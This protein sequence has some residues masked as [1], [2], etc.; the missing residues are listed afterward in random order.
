MNSPM[1]P[2]GECVKVVVR[3]RP[4]NSKELANKNARI[5]DMDLR[6]NCV[7]VK[8]PEGVKAFTFDKIYDWNSTQ[9]AIYK[10]SAKQIVDSVLE[11]YNGTIFAYGQTGTGKTHTMEGRD[12]PPEL[13]GIIP[14]SVQ[15]VYSH[16]EGAESTKEYLIRCCYIEIYNEEIRDLLSKN[17][18]ERLQLKDRPDTGV[19]IQGVSQIVCKDAAE[20]DKLIQQGRKNRSVGETLMNQDSSRSHSILTFLIE[21]SEAGPDGKDMIRAGKLNLVDLAGSE[22]QAKT[23]ATG[24]R[25]KEATKINLSLSALGN[26]ISALVDGKS[27]HIPY[28]DSKLTRLLQDSLGGN[29][30]TC[31][32][33]N[34]G[35]A[36]YNYDETISTLRYANRAKNIKNKAR[37]NEDPKDALMREYKEEINR[38][39]ALLQERGGDIEHGMHAAPAVVEKV[40]EKVVVQKEYV[41]VEKERIVEVE[42][43]KVVEKVVERVIEK[44]MSNENLEQLKEKIRKELM[45]SVMGLPTAEEVPTYLRPKAA[46]LEEKDALGWDL[47]D[48]VAAND[49]ALVMELINRGAEVNIKDRHGM[50]PLHRAVHSEQPALVLCLLVNGAL[51]D[52]KMKDNWTPLHIAAR[53]GNH[54]I[55]DVLQAHGAAMNAKGKNMWTPLHVAALNG[56]LEAMRS[57]IRAKV[58]LNL[59][60]SNGRTAL[61]EAAFRGSLE[62]V[63]E[64]LAAGAKWDILDKDGCTALHLASMNG[65]AEIG[66]LLLEEG[67]AVDAVDVHGRTP[68]QFA[69]AHDFVEMASMLLENGASLEIKDNYG[70]SCIDRAIGNQSYDM[71]TLLESYGA[72]ANEHEQTY[73][74]TPLTKALSKRHSELAQA[75]YM[76][77]QPAT[78]P[79]GGGR[80]PMGGRTSGET[81]RNPSYAGPP[82]GYHASPSGNFVVNPSNG[83]FAVTNPGQFPFGGA[84]PGTDGPPPKKQPGCSCIVQ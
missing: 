80:S 77:N 34:I 67:S 19:Y 58:N 48:A 52:C 76:R 69:V 2:T 18:K 10:D 23:G 83:H 56:R 61:H 5:V 29:T 51:I 49:S 66:K 14:N 70:G 31:M 7:E 41:E 84:N 33:A 12:D 13:R 72:D 82:A 38:L 36:D 74:Q 1:S 43:E 15:H 21:Q 16:V 45:Y 20:I 25:L 22:R 39:K 32:F 75:S 68:L 81:F 6:R 62:V 78:P 42:K 26:V 60:D 64:L 3:C 17:H 57:L 53:I 44:E 46:T 55:V 35:P 27:T 40:V 63:E 79:G 24:D 28:R 8:G 30:K 47:M 73:A 54:T 65:H 9:S 71:I 50:T 11:G 4:L 59:R 37:I